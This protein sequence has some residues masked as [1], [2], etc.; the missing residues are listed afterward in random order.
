MLL[1]TGF[2][3]VSV[4]GACLCL[5]PSLW[6]SLLFIASLFWLL[7]TLYV[8]CQLAYC[9]CSLLGSPID[10]GELE[11]F[12]HKHKNPPEGDRPHWT[13]CQ[14]VSVYFMAQHHRVWLPRNISS[15]S[16]SPQE[17]N[18]TNFLFSL[19]KTIF[20]IRKLLNLSSTIFNNVSGSFT[21][22]QE[23]FKAV[24]QELELGKAAKFTP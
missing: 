23:M 24:S 4:P 11:A 18:F 3:G 19:S 2:Q 12:Q 6:I 20:T 21:H 9:L 16:Q 7:F 10:R 5:R 17:S 1:A 13:C 15:D 8:S 22:P 14:A